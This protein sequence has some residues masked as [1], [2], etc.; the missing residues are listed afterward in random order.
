VRLVINPFFK[1]F[2]DALKATY[3]NKMKSEIEKQT[4][5]PVYDFSTSLPNAHDFCDIQ[6]LNMN[7][8][9][10]LA[11]LLYNNNVLNIE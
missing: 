10:Q 11:Q 6:H 7:G 3:I 4:L 9:K 8:A 2:S 1:P 5:L